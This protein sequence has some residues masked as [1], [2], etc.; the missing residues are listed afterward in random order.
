M[1]KR[2][3]TSAAD[4]LLGTNSSDILLG[5]AGNDRLEGRGGNDVLDG[6]VGLDLLIGGAGNDTYLIDDAREIK[7]STADAG[8]DTVKSTVTYTL[9]LEQENLTLLGSKALNGTG[10]ANAN[11]ITGNAVNNKLT[12][13]AGN[14]TLN[15]GNGNDT[16]TGGDG[17][18]RLLGGAGNDTLVF[19]AL[20]TRG[21][22]GGAGT[23]TLRITDTDLVDLVTLNTG[24]AKFTNVEVIDLSGPGGQT[25]V[26][27][28]ATVEG[29]SSTTNTLQIKG[30]ALDAVEA[31]G[32]WSAIADVVQGGVTFRQFQSGT[33]ILQVQA[34]VITSEISQAPVIT[35]NGGS[36]AN[37]DLAEG[38]ATVTTVVAT[39]VNPGTAFT[40]SLVG[41]ADMALFSIGFSTGELS[42]L[43]PSDF[44]TPLDVG[45]N[46][47]Y[48]I[49]VQVSDG[50]LTDTQAIAVTITDVGES[51]FAAN[52]NLSDLN[53]SNGFE[54]NGEAFADFSGRSVSSAGDVNGDG[55]DDLLIG[56]DGRD[57]N[58]DE[59]GASYVVYGSGTGFAAT[60]N[61]ADL[62]GS[63]GFEIN[64]ETAYDSSGR[65]VSSAGD[66][67][68]DGFDD[69][70]IGA[71]GRAAVNGNYAVESGASYVVFGSG[72]GFAAALNLADLNGSNGFEI[73]GE[74]VGDRSGL[75]VSSAGDVNGDGFD[76]L[77]IGA[78]GR[79]VN[80]IYA[81]ASYVLFGC[82]FRDEAAF[83]GGTDNDSF[84][85]TS[86]NEILLGGQ[87]N[88]TLNGGAGADVLNGGAGIDALTGDTGAD[89]LE[90]GSGADTLNGGDDNDRLAGDEG[91]DTLDGD[92]GNDVLTGGGDND[93][94]LFNDTL[95]A[96]NVDT[97]MDFGGAGDT[98]FDLIHLDDTIFTAL[99]SGTLAGAAFESG[100]GLSA[101]T[102]ADGRIVYD[103]TSGALYYD[104]DGTGATEAIQFATI[105]T[106]VAGL[107]ATDFF[108][109]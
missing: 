44:E 91:A 107:N 45:A 32:A 79:D 51:G 35:S 31:S 87:G 24:S 52:L 54:I 103:T 63:N 27:D 49:T 84:T 30:T 66:V 19:D 82:D 104:A 8:I 36:A 88:D 61:L 56:A 33:A 26:L 71:D 46:N 59:A 80:G 1:A 89:T 98:V 17:D 5:L 12:G 102:T 65:P 90:G 34:G 14:D 97:L 76:D 40:Y 99:T 73:N 37:L 41:G 81:G 42:F 85:G 93:M 16:L 21:V 13:G 6:G 23:D 55:F 53:G 69:L 83:A 20:D 7:K 18:D 74:T 3:G 77:L 60:L 101:A 106:H 15:G 109:V 58:G 108:V 25:V 43:A 50:T 22:D 11:V 48:D 67:N 96:G 78:F 86:A 94:F 62:N 72:A 38:I 70:L 39:D 92:L 10:N 64:G 9:S 2:T 75:S 47:V 95:G 105:A 28:Q 100:A 29:L 68:G 57:V 4:K